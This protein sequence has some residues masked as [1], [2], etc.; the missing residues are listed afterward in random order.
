MDIEDYYVLVYKYTFSNKLSL[1]TLIP[2]TQFK[3]RQNNCI[4]VSYFLIKK[5]VKTKKNKYNK[6]RKV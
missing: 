4:I 1:V 5:N 2:Y 3:K 6:T